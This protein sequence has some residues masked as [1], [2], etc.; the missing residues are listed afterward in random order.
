MVSNQTKNGI[1]TRIKNLNILTKIPYDM[2]L[3]VNACR[4]A[5]GSKQEERQ[6]KARCR[7]SASGM[8][9]H[10]FTSLHHCFTQQCFPIIHHSID[11]N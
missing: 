6:G 3:F 7:G 1:C 8:P 2:P 5:A 4:S 10:F 9:T 11:T